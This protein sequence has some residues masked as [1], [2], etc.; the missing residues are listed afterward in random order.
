MTEKKTANERIEDVVKEELNKANLGKEKET[1]FTKVKKVATSETAKK[2]YGA[3]ALGIAQGVM[4]RFTFETLG[5][6]GSE[7]ETE[8][9]IEIE[10]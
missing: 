9:I 5:D 3:M 4:A 10:E 2:V 8:T 7:N 1:I 6:L